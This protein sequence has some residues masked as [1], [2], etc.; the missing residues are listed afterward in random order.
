MPRWWQELWWPWLKCERVGHRML[1]R[2]RRFYRPAHSWRAVAEKV[3]EEREFCARC[4]HATD[5][6]EAY[7]TDI[8]CLTMPDD[9]W[10]EF[11][12]TG[13]TDAW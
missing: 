4:E 6:R 11:A 7:V 8:H 5:W 10:E 1:T 13:R 12:K 2:K 9:K 3:T